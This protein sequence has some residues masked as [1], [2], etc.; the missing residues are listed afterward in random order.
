M[1]RHSAVVEDVEVSDEAF[2]AAAIPGGEDHGGGIDALAGDQEG[3]VALEALDLGA[4]AGE[5]GFERGD[6]PVV[7]RWVDPRAAKTCRIALGRARNPVGRQV[8]VDVPL[9]EA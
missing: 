7:D 6:E 8:A 2:Q 3:G 9:D 5:A 1:A 4:D